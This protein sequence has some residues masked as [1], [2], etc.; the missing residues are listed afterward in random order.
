VPTKTDRILGYLPS[1]FR[2]QPR[3]NA[4]Y[5]TTDAFGGELQ[6]AENS[7]AAVM[8][9]HW[10]DHADLFAELFKDLPQL[11]ALY[12]LAPR[13]DEEIEDFRR[14]LKRYVRTFIEGTVTVQGILRIAAEGLGLEIADAEDELDPWWRRPDE[15]L[16]TTRARLD[17]ASAVVF[18]GAPLTAV[19]AD[20][21][22]ATVTGTVDL[23]AGE[24]ILDTPDLLVAV[25][26][27]APTSVD[28]STVPNPAAAI[29]G[30]VAAVVN[31]ALGA[32]V[33]S[34]VG[35]RLRLQSPTTGAGSALALE[36]VD[37][38]AAPLVLGLRSR[39][40]RGSSATAAALRGR[41]DL[42]GGVELE[43][44]RYVRVRVDGAQEAEIDL[45]GAAPAHA[46]LEDLRT[47]IN[48]A[49]GLEVAA[50]EEGV[51]MLR[52][53]TEGASGTIE[54]LA[55]AAQDATAL[56]FGDAPRFVSG[57]DARPARLVGPD[58]S[59]GLDLREASQLA[60]AV[61]GA[62]A[63]SVDCAGLD[64]A[65]TRPGEVVERLNDVL[66]PVAGYDGR[67]ITIASLATGPAATIA[68]EPLPERDAGEAI[69]GLGPRAFTGSDEVTARLEG[70]GAPVD[71]RAQNVLRLSVD[72]APARDVDL[73]AGSVAAK[74]VTPLELAA[75]IS[76][77]LGPGIASVEAGRLVLSSSTPGSA[78]SL[79]VEPLEE[80]LVRRFVTRALVRGEA[81][82]TL[83]GVLQ[84]EAR[85]EPARPAVIAGQAD[86]SRG[87]DLRDRESLR[88]AVDGEQP[89][90]IRV[91]GARPRATTLDQIT[92]AINDE[93]GEE[94]A[95]AVGGRLQ[96]VSSTVGAESNIVLGAPT[97]EDAL[98]RVGLAPGTAHGRD[99]VD[100]RF[101]GTV[102]LSPDVDLSAGATVRL[103]IDADEH[104]VDCAG[105][106]PAHTRIDE[107]VD[108]VNNAFGVRVANIEG[109]R[110]R[111]QSRAGGT[112]GTLEFLEPTGGPDGTRAIFGVDPPRAYHGSDAQPA[113]L[114]GTVDAAGGLAPG[115]G[116]FLRVTVDGS[117]PA[118]VDL[119]AGAADPANP[120][121]DEAI[122]AFEAVLPGVASRD[123]GHLVLASPTTGAGGRLTLEAYES[124]DAQPAL[125]G[126]AS[127]EAHGSDGGDA[128]ITGQVDLLQPVDLSSR[129]TL[130]LALDG[131]RPIE[132]DVAGATAATTFL[133]EV[134]A[135]I[136]ARVPGLAEATE[137]DRLRL[138]WRGERLAVLPAR[139]L[140]VVEY[141]PEPKTELPARLRHGQTW[142]IDN[143]GAA[144]ATAEI[145][146]LALRG[147]ATPG[148]VNVAAAVEI[149][150]LAAVDAGGR[151]LLRRTAEGKLEATVTSPGGAA[152]PVP[153]EAVLVRPLEDGLDEEPL[154]VARG[155]SEWRYL[156]CVG[157][158]WNAA[159]FDVDAFA[160]GPC[161]EIGVFDASRWGTVADA[162]VAAVFGDA[163]APPVE[164]VEA[165]VRWTRHA[166]GRFAVNLPAELPARF[167]AR[168]GDGRFGSGDEFERYRDAVTE[169][170]GD[171]K[172]LA[173]L[174]EHSRLVEGGHVD[175]VPLGWSA[176]TLPFRRPRRLTIGAPGARAALYLREE[177][178]PGYVRLQ[179]KEDGA[180]GASIEVT[181][182]RSGPASFDVT[183]SFAAGRFENAREAV[184]GR[185]LSASAAELLE[186]GPVGVL[187]AKAAGIDAAVWRERT[188]RE[189]AEEHDP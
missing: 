117:P 169:P 7:L 107:V 52:S 146:F 3:P 94:V 133:D 129:S 152:S 74:A 147:I 176:V 125:L 181:A 12:G 173:E 42:S 30:D 159:H 99:A 178:V 14:H 184:R 86:L 90:N 67:S 43:P 98:E 166:P 143:D 111:L 54:L 174:V 162:P 158:R 22:A 40:A 10:A 53:P 154:R 19:G 151:L 106:D 101:L 149:R 9:A 187:E 84:A 20:A 130:V 93:L 24:N 37:D 23:S 28:L 57:T 88:I 87:V 70:P 179:A 170:E 1:T 27:G 108:A 102:D 135:A 97:P 6:S 182:P 60:V 132:L 72:G 81:A 156:E 45:R 175:T 104:E 83:L 41:A 153:E 140:E 128:I 38:D 31:A 124:Q 165:T 167:G 114:V 95:R 91:A 186:P 112:A 18:G 50:A 171:S 163:D 11:A 69:L 8:Q 185:P 122:A 120:S 61:D 103:R 65:T 33:A 164:S 110:I 80:T 139:V 77:Q 100:V 25:D 73:R 51:L 160:G 134:V 138:R 71:L 188:V 46:S 85:G 4:L 126:A 58:V 15:T 89:S 62:D 13:E 155:R 2:A 63:V 78:G 39:R 49:L 82:E 127:S 64:P 150:L 142:T 137:N 17:D 118:D 183:I 26:G 168:F 109:V 36:N 76:S 48:A 116:R 131:G 123:D 59:A 29:A 115:E 172:D 145:D 75:A 161:A 121:L 56:V 189:S 177:E 144:Q 68:V 55:P 157:T 180:H 79:A 44:L 105:A 141:P 66:G 96:L 16:T 119:G 21:R 34:E 35:G 148:I 5:S 136:N 113:R 47:R 92:T 32:T